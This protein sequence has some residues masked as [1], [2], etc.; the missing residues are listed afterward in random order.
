M[1]CSIGNLTISIPKRLV[2]ALKNKGNK[3]KFWV[4]FWFVINFLIG[5]VYN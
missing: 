3:K 4:I 5:M 2:D 1:S